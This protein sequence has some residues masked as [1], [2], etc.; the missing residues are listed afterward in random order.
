MV[1]LEQ[2]MQR[3]RKK[4]KQC[5]QLKGTADANICGYLPQDLTSFSSLQFAILNCSKARVE[6]TE[7]ILAKS[8]GCKFVQN[9]TQ[10]ST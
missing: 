1:N 8:I 7:S 5:R 6:T 10:A 2:T 3:P 4:G 9:H